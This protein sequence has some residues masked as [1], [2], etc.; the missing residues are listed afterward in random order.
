MQ[1]KEH[2]QDTLNTKEVITTL[3][4]VCLYLKQFSVWQLNI[5]SPTLV[6]LY[7][8]VY[9]AATFVIPCKT[10][11]PVPES[12]DSHEM[13]KCNVLY[14]ISHLKRAYLKEQTPRMDHLFHKAFIQY[15]CIREGQ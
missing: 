15:V 7:S 13:S 10:P 3:S 11:G 5:T 2:R 4:Y 14:L 12:H 1:R 6:P 9:G 8:Y